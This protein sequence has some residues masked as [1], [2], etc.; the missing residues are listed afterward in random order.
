[1]I[2]GFFLATFYVVDGFCSK[3]IFYPSL[4]FGGAPLV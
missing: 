4:S 3:F 2:F 1:M